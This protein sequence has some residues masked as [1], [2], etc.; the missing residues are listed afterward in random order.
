VPTLLLWGDRDP[1]SP[2]PV[3]A[4]LAKALPD[5][6]LRIVGGGH[7]DFPVTHPDEVAGFILEHLG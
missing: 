3:G 6:D 5:A 7:H 1:V 4:A 2:I